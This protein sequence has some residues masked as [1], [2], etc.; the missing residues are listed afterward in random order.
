MF[1]NFLINGLQSNQF[2]DT[3]Y[4]TNTLAS[5]SAGFMLCMEAAYNYVFYPVN[6]CLHG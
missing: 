4:F 2:H 5:T 6:Q 1:Y 3:D